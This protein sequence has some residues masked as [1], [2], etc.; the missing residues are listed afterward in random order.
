MV[1]KPAVDPIANPIGY[2]R[3]VVLAVETD[4]RQNTEPATLMTSGRPGTMAGD[5]PVTVRTRVAE[6]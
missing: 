2:V 4:S 3:M 6:W 1:V 5:P